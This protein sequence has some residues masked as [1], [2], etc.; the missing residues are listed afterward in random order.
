[1]GEITF[2]HGEIDCKQI[3]KNLFRVT[4]IVTKP[5]KAEISMD[6]ASEEIARQ[7]LELF[8]QGEPYSHLDKR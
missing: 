2:E 5:F 7:K 6:G 8:F 4:T 1:M 3:H